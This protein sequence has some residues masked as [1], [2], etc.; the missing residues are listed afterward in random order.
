MMALEDFHLQLPIRVSLVSIQCLIIL[1]L[2]SCI[3]GGAMVAIDF[4]DGSAALVSGIDETLME[5]GLERDDATTKPDPSTIVM[6]VS[7]DAMQ[8][9]A[10]PVES[11]SSVTFDNSASTSAASAVSAPAEAKSNVDQGTASLES[12]KAS[13]VSPATTK[14]V[15]STPKR[16]SDDYQDARAR[17]RAQA[18]SEAEKA[19]NPWWTAATYLAQK[20][21]ESIMDRKD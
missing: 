1:C 21:K 5:L 8:S 19:S 9:S 6:P 14:Q 18:A 7:S 17:M 2:I 13:S 10:T 16:P 12:T 15:A 4:E 11:S 3:G 20:A